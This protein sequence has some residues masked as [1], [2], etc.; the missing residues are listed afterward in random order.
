MSALKKHLGAPTGPVREPAVETRSWLSPLAAF[1]RASSQVAERTIAGG[2]RALH[3]SAARRELAQEERLLHL[4]TGSKEHARVAALLGAGVD[5]LASNVSR[6]ATRRAFAPI[7]RALANRDDYGAMLLLEAMKPGQVDLPEGELGDSPLMIA[8]KNGLTDA[9]Q[10]LIWRGA[11]PTVKNYA[12]VSPF[13]EACRRGDVV[14]M[15]ECIAAAQRVADTAHLFHAAEVDGTPAL[16][17]LLGGAAPLDVKTKYLHR[18]SSAGVDLNGKYGDAGHSAAH[19]VCISGDA[20][21]LG[22]LASTH[23]SDINSVSTLDGVTPIMAA[24]W[25]NQAGTITKAASLPGVYVNATRSAD[26]SSALHIAAVRGNLEA[27]TALLAAGANISARNK[28]GETAADLAAHF[29]QKAASSMLNGHI[30]ENNLV[31]RAGLALEALAKQV[32]K[33]PRP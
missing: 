28:E 21:L 20:E 18:F 33:V 5:P 23:S 30:A 24:A 31:R 9:A 16:F 2:R 11:N 12:G 19:F 26:G 25:A 13:M 14:I 8:V 29:G 22:E 6:L 10:A 7:H 3:D 17:H 32:P 27:C 15:D 1:A 4:Y